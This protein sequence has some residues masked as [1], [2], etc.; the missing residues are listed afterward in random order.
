MKLKKFDTL[1]K[2]RFS[3][4]VI[5]R[6]EREAKLEKL[7]HEQKAAIKVAPPAWIP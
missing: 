6:I 1:L 2:K 3:K 7:T 5:E 4:E